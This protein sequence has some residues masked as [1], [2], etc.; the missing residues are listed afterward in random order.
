MKR[1]I[2]ALSL[3][4]APLLAGAEEAAPT[5]MYVAAT[6][7]TVSGHPGA[8]NRFETFIKRAA[9]AHAKLDTKRHW[10][11]WQQEM[12]N[13]RSYTLARTFGSMTAMDETPMNPIAEAFGP[14]EIAK[15]T[16]DHEVVASVERGVW[17]QRPDLAVMP[18]SPV[19]QRVIWLQATVRAG[20]NERF[21]AYV[22]KVAEATREVAPERDLCARLRVPEHLRLL[23]AHQLCPAGRSPCHVRIGAASRG[24]RRARGA[25]S[26]SGASGDRGISGS[27]AGP[28]PAR[29]GLSAAGG[30]APRRRGRLAIAG[31][32]CIAIAQPDRGYG[33]R[34]SETS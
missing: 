25:T 16:P 11:A 8:Q 1:I 24:V 9:E 27:A 32:P 22:A 2:L 7:L 4:T 26:G 31:S 15:L 20:E 13:P 14:E 12:G 19:G 33:T 10:F 18:D 3:M 21:E 6:N 17:V 5:P 23:C 28:T 34:S 30:V 29:P